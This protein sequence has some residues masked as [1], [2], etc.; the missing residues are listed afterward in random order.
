[1]YAVL[2][3]ALSDTAAT[4]LIL[5]GGALG[6]GILVLGLTA[7]AIHRGAK[8]EALERQQRQRV[9]ATALGQASAGRGKAAAAAGAAVDEPGAHDP[10]PPQPY[11]AREPRSHKPYSRPYRVPKQESPRA[12]TNGHRPPGSSATGVPTAPFPPPDDE[13]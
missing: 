6:C 3:V 10:Y 12:A 11:S 13:D 9:R 1:M 8:E 4:G 2:N 5:G 7:L